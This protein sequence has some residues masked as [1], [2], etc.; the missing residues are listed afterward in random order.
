MRCFLRTIFV[1][2]YF[3]TSCT[4]SHAEPYSLDELADIEEYLIGEPSAEIRLALSA[5]P[6]HISSQA[7]V[8]VFRPDGYRAVRDSTNGFVCLVERSWAGSVSY[9]GAFW[10]P[11]IRS[12]ICYNEHAAKR[13]LPLYLL[14]TELVLAGKSRAEIATVVAQ[15]VSSGKL[16]PPTELAMS[17]MMSSG[18]FLHPDIGRWLPHLMIWV[19][20]MHQDDWGMNRL[21]GP[22]PVVFRNP[23]GPFSMVVIP[24]D[25]DRFIDP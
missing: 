6:E 25:E 24:Y 18:Q 10:D 14:R 21:A 5:A 4:A 19:P 23:G 20:Y 8:W 15:S 12:P 2:A 7:G 11:T 17:Y 1:S 22:D 3:F 16:T 9:V 13:V